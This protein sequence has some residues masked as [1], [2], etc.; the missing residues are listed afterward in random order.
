MGNPSVIPDLSNTPV[1]GTGMPGGGNNPTMPNVMPPT[2]PPV[3]TPGVQPN[4]PQAQANTP[5]APAQA[6]ADNSPAAQH[7]GIFH[8]VLGMLGGG[9]NRPQVD[10][11]G[12]PIMNPDGT[13][14]MAPASAKQLGMGILAGAISGMVAGMATP[15][16]YNQVAPGRFQPDYSGSFAAGAAAA[17]PFTQEGAQTEA[18]KKAD[19]IKSR[20]FATMDHN[21][22]M[23]AMMIAN[24]KADTEDQQN[25]VDTFGSMGEAMEGEYARGNVVDAQ[26]NPIDLYSYRGIDGDKLQQL[27]ASKDPNAR[28]T[29]NQVMPVQVIQV[30]Q[31]DGSTKAVTLFDVYNPNATVKMTENL[32]K[33]YPKLANVGDNT[34]VPVRMLA[35][36]AQMRAN[37]GL[38]AS[39]LDDHIEG[40]NN[41]NPKNKISKDFDLAEAGKGDPAIQALYPLINK[42][43]TDPFDAMVND[44]RKDPAFANDPKIQAGLAHLQ[45]KMG[46]TSDGLVNQAQARTEALTQGKKGPDQQ[47]ADETAIANFPKNAQ[48]RYPTVTTGQIASVAEGLGKNPTVK[49]LKDANDEIQKMSGQNNQA[50]LADQD[51]DDKQ[52]KMLFDY[53]IAGNQRLTL[54]NA[55]DEMLVD[56]RTGHPIPNKSLTALKASQTEINRKQFAT[57]VLHIADSLRKA[58]AAGNLPNAPLVGGIT[59]KILMQSGLSSEDAQKTMTEISLLQSAATGAHVGGRFSVPILEKMNK[60]L[61]LN[62]NDAQFAGSLD[63][64]TDTMKTYEDN[65]GRFSVAEWK[66]LPPQERARLMGSTSTPANVAPPG[67]T[68]IMKNGMPI[69]YFTTDG[70]RVNF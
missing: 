12:N 20:Q 32:R 55:P 69:G 67:T 36:W 26:N 66:S 60:L 42:Y 18:Q 14:R 3:G 11:Q 41:A 10:A 33:D 1:V 21:L 61:S 52:Q 27:L 7:A 38:A 54:D 56:Q 13:V 24:H 57:S 15:T 39:G 58:Q 49:D 40:Y 2:A 19:D 8:K 51:L 47:P 16:K 31:A 44:I 53:G 46:F 63:A 59:N 22:K 37:E 9:M 34:K 30:P 23:H 48:T 5:N 68:P 35:T 64:I 45:E 6:P 65:G 17:Q 4:Q 43:R 70:K 25:T 50:R 62:M 29:M 28:V